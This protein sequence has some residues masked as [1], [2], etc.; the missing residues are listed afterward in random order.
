MAYSQQNYQE[1]KGKLA[2]MIHIPDKSEYMSRAVK[3]N[4]YNKIAEL[5][6]KNGIYADPTHSRFV[7]TANVVVNDKYITSTAPPQHAYKLDVS[8]YIIDII[9]GQSFASYASSVSG[10]GTNETKA[11]MNALKNIN[12]NNPAYR[13]F[14]EEGKT[15]VVNFLNSECD[16]IIR[17]TKALAKMGQYGKA[18][19]QLI[20]VPGFCTCYSQCMDLA[21][22]IFQQKVD[23]ECQTALLEATNIW[24][25]EQSWNAAERAGKI[26]LKIDPH[27]HCYTDAITLSEKI[28]QRIREVDQREWDF[29]TAI[30]NRKLELQKDMIEAYRDVA[31]AAYSYPEILIQYGY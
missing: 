18:L 6:S 16:H 24:N 21:E 8:F 11:Y 1:A 28:A 15:N 20:N 2:L 23:T 3:E 26:L 30:V 12:V 29:F 25:A 22:E 5:I 17:E 13:Q 27:S 7:L 31:V 10:V 4:L 9:N 19:W 14:L